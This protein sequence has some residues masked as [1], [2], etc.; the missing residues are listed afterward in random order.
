[1][2]PCKKKR[3]PPEP[4]EALAKFGKKIDGF[5][6]EK[7]LGNAAVWSALRTVKPNFC[8]DGG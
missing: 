1:L 3:N 5:G 6:I 8:K 7:F 4:G 2:K